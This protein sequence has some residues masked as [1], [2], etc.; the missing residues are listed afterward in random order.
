VSGEAVLAWASLAMAA[1]GLLGGLVA[2]C[3]WLVR[4]LGR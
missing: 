2:G 4:R 1:A 3:A